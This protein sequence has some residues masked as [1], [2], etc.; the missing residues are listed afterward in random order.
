MGGR[1]FERM[2]GRKTPVTG[3]MVIHQTSIELQTGKRRP[4][5]WDVIAPLTRHSLSISVVLSH[6]Q[7]EDS[8]TKGV[9]SLGLDCVTNFAI[10][11]GMLI[12]NR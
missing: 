9:I 11:I 6:R 5:R 12:A 3:S 1:V 8:I 4:T 10:Q 7:T 2:Q